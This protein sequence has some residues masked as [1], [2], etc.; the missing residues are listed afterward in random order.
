MMTQRRRLARRYAVALGMLAE[1]QGL[2]DRVEKDLDLVLGLLAESKE[3]R[4]YLYNDQISSTERCEFLESAFKE[5][6]APLSLNF[7]FLVIR[8][9][10]VRYLES[11]IDA[12]VEYANARRGIVVV[13][14]TTAKELDQMLAEHLTEGLGKALE[15]QV[16]LRA[17]VDPT[18][19]GGVVVRVGDLL[20]DGSAVSRLAQLGRTLKSAQL[21]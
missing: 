19:L 14:V 20:I 21:N 5:E 13:R 1:E 6:L 3:F 16:R 15:S 4:Y 11:I 17:S 18:L 2:L 9:H 8:K 7:L 10:R 12:Y